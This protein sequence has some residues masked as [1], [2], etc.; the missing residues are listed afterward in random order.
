MLIKMLR[1]DVR[2]YARDDEWILP[3]VG[4]CT[5][6]L[7]V[8]DSD[9]DTIRVRHGTGEAVRTFTRSEFEGFAIIEWIASVHRYECG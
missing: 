9:D 3:C 7:Y 2:A 4:L 5:E 8:S 6:R 1:S